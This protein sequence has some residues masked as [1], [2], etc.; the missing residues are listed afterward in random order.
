MVYGHANGA[1]LDETLDNARNYAEQGFSAI[2]L[3]SGVPGL[4]ST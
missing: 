2:R 3:R 4:A 1:T